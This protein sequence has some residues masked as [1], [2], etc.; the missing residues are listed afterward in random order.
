MRRASIASKE[1]PCNR[2]RVS[3]GHSTLATVYE[4][5]T[6]AEEVGI[7]VSCLPSAFSR[8]CRGVPI[9]ISNGVWACS[10]R[11]RISLSCTTFV[12]WC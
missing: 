10:L 11:R 3:R 6:S 9:G 2:F 1:Q 5:F 12:L 8:H 4:S 7:H